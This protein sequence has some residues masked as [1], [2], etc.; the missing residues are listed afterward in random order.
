MKRLK[1]LYLLEEESDMNYLQ[2]HIWCRDSNWGGHYDC[3][4]LVG[5]SSYLEGYKEDWDNI[6]VDKS[7]YDKKVRSK[8]SGLFLDNPDCQEIPEEELCEMF[9]YKI[10][11]LHPDVLEWLT[12]EVPDKGEEKGW[13]VGSDEYVRSDA[14]YS[15]SIFFQ[16]RSDAM[17]FIKRW[18]K[19]KKP[20]HYCQYFTDVRKTLNLKTL[21]YEE[22]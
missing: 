7:F 11:T 10:K 1:V 15:Y 18:S 19:W 8:F 21:K 6:L 3:R 9:T 20:I 13:C 4:H 17:K 16:R 22:K 12:T 2:N 14:S 5:L